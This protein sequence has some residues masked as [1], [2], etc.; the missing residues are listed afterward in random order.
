MVPR[1]AEQGALPAGSSLTNRN[2]ASDGQATPTTGKTVQSTESKPMTKTKPKPKIDTRHIRGR[3]ATDAINRV[4]RFYNAS[5]A[6]IFAEL[7]QNARRAGATRIDV[8]VGNEEIE[9][10]D[11]GR[12]IGNPQLLVDFGGS[13]CPGRWHEDPAGMGMYALA[14]RR[15]TIL[16]T[17]IGARPWKVTLTPEVFGG[18][19]AAE[20]QDSEEPAKGGTIVR[21]ERREDDNA[22]SA[23]LAAKYLEVAVYIDRKRTPQRR[24]EL[25]TSTRWVMSNKDLT[26]TVHKANGHLPYNDVL[27]INFFGH[28]VC[29]AVGAPR[30]ET[31]ENTWYAEVSVVECPELQ[32]VLP[33]REKVVR[34]AFLKTL[35]ERAER[36]IFE[37]IANDVERV[38]VPYITHLR[39]KALGIELGTAEPMLRQWAARPGNQ[40]ESRWPFRRPLTQTLPADAIKVSES[41]CAPMQAVLEHAVD[42]SSIAEQ[43][44]M[45]DERYAG[46]EWYNKLPEIVDVQVVV[47]DNAGDPP[48]RTKTWQKSRR[49]DQIWAVARIRNEDGSSREL[50][51]ETDIALGECAAPC[52]P[53]VAGIL[54]AKHYS[55]DGDEIHE[56]AEKGLFYVNHGDEADDGT[57][58]RGFREKLRYEIKLALSGSEQATAAAIREA[59]LQSSAELP[60]DAVTTIRITPDGTTTV[61]F[62][63]MAPEAPGA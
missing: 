33:A 11:D 12:G 32:L 46:F 49:V 29:D 45:S 23:A 34:N 47:T 54:I 3:V 44:V 53:G 40:S 22:R 52:E 31:I 14:G 16:S 9:V 18:K 2:V 27:R 4:T 35:I 26:F 17:P 41:V 10:R 59:I 61:A 28:V 43:L 30:V 13:D 39:A 6:S 15:T 21:F 48:K 8:R 1:A 58:R 36:A 5:A 20:I 42:N 55:G 38:P 51:I 7:F 37:G 25:E 56:M 63:A 57:Q 50:R 19:A 24:F 60:A 62:E